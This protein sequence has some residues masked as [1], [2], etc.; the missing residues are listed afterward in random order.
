MTY[1]KLTNDG[2]V[3]YSI[4][5]LRRDNP[6]TSFPDQP[7]EDMLKEWNVY[8]Y[9]VETKPSYNNLIQQITEGE[10]FKN[11]EGNWV[12]SWLVENLSLELAKHNIRKKR[13][14]LLSSSDWTQV[15]DAPVDRVEWAAY[16]QAL[17]DIPEQEGFPWDVVWPTEPINN[18]TTNN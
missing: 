3:S 14:T 15:S 2:P 1:L 17:R 10:F 13:D 5:Q 12:Q 18:T 4:R 9:T 7:S 16:R 6:R 11:A 8:P